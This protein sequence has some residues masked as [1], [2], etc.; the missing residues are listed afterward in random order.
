MLTR[1][2]AG[3][4]LTET[5]QDSSMM[6]GFYPQSMSYHSTAQAGSTTPFS[7]KDI[8]CLAQQQ[9]HRYPTPAM[10]A[11]QQEH[12]LFPLPDESFLVENTVFPCDITAT[13]EDARSSCSYPTLGYQDIAP[14]SSSPLDQK[15]PSLSQHQTVS[16]QEVCRSMETKR[17][18]ANHQ[19]HNHHHQLGGPGDNSNKPPSKTRQRR[20]PRVLFSQ[21][22]VYELERRFKQQRYLSAPE[23][24][25][26]AALL[27]LTP[28]QVK[29]WFQNRRYKSKRQRQDKSL[30]L[31]GQQY[32]P[33]RVAVPVLVRDGKPCIGNLGTTPSPHPP[34]PP[35]PPPPYGYT[36]GNY[37]SG[38]SQV[39]SNGRYV[40]ACT[41][42]SGLPAGGGVHTNGASVYSQPG[43]IQ[44]A[45]RTW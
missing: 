4:T 31:T 18:T 38:V 39:T 15:V 29:I 26:L 33:R 45:V 13:S 36:C 16:C 3:F 2:C 28:T 5:M 17:N 8:L 40:N 9:H 7:V 1:K 14:A 32:P 41:Y 34:P 19:H 37:N 20:K 12:N 30:E 42:P 27:K 10:Q 11:Y 43:N 44:Q 6:S 23:R 21:A 24:D 35:P 25:Q 22:Q